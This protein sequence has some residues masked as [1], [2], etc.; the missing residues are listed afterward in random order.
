MA[1]P[2]GSKDLKERKSK[3]FITAQQEREIVKDYNRGVPS[4]DIRNKYSISN[5]QLS[6]IRK[7]LII[8]K[9]MLIAHYNFALDNN[10][11]RRKFFPIIIRKKIKK[12]E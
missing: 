4:L 12:I 3:V 6:N 10:I 2:K 8:N 7:S 1:R 11:K 9:T 5:A